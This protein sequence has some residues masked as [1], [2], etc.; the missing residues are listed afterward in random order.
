MWSGNE[1]RIKLGGT[2][3]RILIKMT[4]Q[5]LGICAY[6]HFVGCTPRS[7]SGPK[8][9]ITFEMKKYQNTNNGV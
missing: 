8:R 4:R 5:I 1:T 2:G 9:L 6:M 3:L 7:N